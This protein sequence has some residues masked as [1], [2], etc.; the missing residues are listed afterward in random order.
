MCL[1]DMNFKNLPA[2]DVVDKLLYEWG[3]KKVVVQGTAD[4]TGFFETSLFHGDYEVK[5]DD[6]R[7]TS[8]NSFSQK[9][10]VQSKPASPETPTLLVQLPYAN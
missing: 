5:V 4:S 9:L 1:T 10:S 2:G 7:V 6:P 8:Y 3:F